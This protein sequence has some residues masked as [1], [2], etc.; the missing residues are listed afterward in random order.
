M[1]RGEIK[2]QIS[3]V[4][5]DN[6]VFIND[7]ETGLDELMEIDSLTYVSV[8]VDLESALGVELDELTI[9]EQEVTYAGFIDKIADLVE[10]KL[11]EI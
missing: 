5:R 4:L 10:Q 6:G 2:E 9:A 3:G 8:M 7:S 1:D 11:K